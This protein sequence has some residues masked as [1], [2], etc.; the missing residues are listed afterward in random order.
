MCERGIE[1]G[2]LHQVLTFDT[3]TNIRTM[4]TELQD[5]ELLARIDGGNL[6]A[7]ELKYHLNCLVNLRNRY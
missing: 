7:K 6:I 1:E 3:D 5:T 2:E 4:I